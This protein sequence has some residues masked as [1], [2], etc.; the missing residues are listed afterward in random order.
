[1]PLFY[2]VKAPASIL[3]HLKDYKNITQETGQFEA[4]NSLFARWLY[5]LRQKRIW[6]RQRLFEC[7]QQQMLRDHSAQVIFV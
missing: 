1:M 7:D 5:N 2:Q 6:H 3:E 4:N